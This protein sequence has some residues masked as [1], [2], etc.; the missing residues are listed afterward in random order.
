MRAALLA[1]SVLMAPQAAMAQSCPQPL[2]D[3]RRL[4]LVVADKFTSTTAT[5]RRFER[6]SPQEPWK[7]SGGPAKALIGHNGLGWAQAFRQFAHPGEPAKTEGDKRNPAGFFSIGPSFGFAA[8]PVPGYLHIVEGT[9]CV[10]DAA[11][12]AYNTIT[13]RAK[14]GWRVRGEN[15]WRVR[16]YARGLLIDY[17]TDA[18]AR[19][20]SCIFIH[21]WLPGKTGT[22]GCVAV[23]E[24]QLVSLQNFAQDRAVLAVLPKSALDRF[25]GCLP[26]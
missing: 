19:A 18:K 25:K 12:P 23:R 8:S 17:P 3:A 26:N 10:D 7:E 15:M 6:G 14:I 13:T 24:P 9:T 16:D 21:L 2:A 4:V 11:S 22:S 20:G 1:L 5:L